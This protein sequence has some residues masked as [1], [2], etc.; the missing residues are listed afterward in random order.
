M[1][2]APPYQINTKTA[3]GG[4]TPQA[5][6]PI[7]VSNFDP[8]DPEYVRVY[9]QYYGRVVPLL[10][11]LHHLLGDGPHGIN[12]LYLLAM[13][14]HLH[15]AMHNRAR[16]TGRLEL[17]QGW[18]AVRGVL[19]PQSEA[20]AS[21]GPRG[22]KQGVDPKGGCE[23]KVVGIVDPHPIGKVGH[24]TL[25][26]CKHEMA[27]RIVLPDLAYP[28]LPDNAPAVAVRVY[29]TVIYLFRLRYWSKYPDA[30]VP[31]SKWFVSQ[32]SALK[33]P[34]AGFSASTAAR[35]VSALAAIGIISPAG[36]VDCGHG[37]M[38]TG[39]RLNTEVL[40][41]AA[42]VVAEAMP[43]PEVYRASLRAYANALDDRTDQRPYWQ[44]KERQAQFEQYVPGLSACSGMRKR[45]AMIRARL[46]EDA[47]M[48]APVTEVVPVD[49]VPCPVASAVIALEVLQSQLET[50]LANLGTHPTHTQQ[51]AFYRLFCEAT[52]QR[53]F[54][55]AHS[56]D[57]GRAFVASP[58][59]LW[60]SRLNW[61]VSP[62]VLQEVDREEAR[63]KASLP[64]RFSTTAGGAFHAR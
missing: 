21:V 45:A 60:F 30:P 57:G 11:V 2:I 50:D 29:S 55:S 32:V 1:T 33:L 10:H 15:T 39:Y 38:G 4:R 46:A 13:P 12:P 56:P 19:I 58:L 23:P 54:I 37:R 5:D 7:Y 18:V 42:P 59:N 48:T 63:E 62:E 3:S 64:H 26:T 47:L 22:Q 20:T 17:P 44:L 24:A 34:G 16:S 51:V 25:D 49:V 31:L 53:H 35:G 61:V 9:E 43:I 36:M 8:F 6:A 27:G 52:R 40:I 41:N 28:P 14:R